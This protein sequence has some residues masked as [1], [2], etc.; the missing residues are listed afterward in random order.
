MNVPPNNFIGVVV[1]QSADNP[2]SVIRMTDIRE[3]IT[4][5]I[6]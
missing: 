6:R 5:D 3:G 4:S 1:L 2:S